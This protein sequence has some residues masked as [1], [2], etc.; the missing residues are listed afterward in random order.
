M[1]LFYLLS[2]ALRWPLELRRQRDE[3]QAEAERQVAFIATLRSRM[4]SIA[5]DRDFMLAQ[6]LRMA[7]ELIAR[8]GKIA[9]QSQ[10][11]RILER[12][13]VANGQNW[14]QPRGK[15]ITTGSMEN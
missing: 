8:Q 15:W 1:K 13:I 9:E 10:Q 2:H 6:N 11:I 4:A 7:Q 12:H 14:T 3:A 5:D